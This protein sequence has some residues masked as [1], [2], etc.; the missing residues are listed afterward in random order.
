MASRRM[1]NIN[2]INSARFLKL[3]IDTQNLYFHLCMRADDD[4]VVEAYAVVR[5]IGSSEDNLKLLHAKELVKVLNEDL[6]AYITDWNSHNNIRADRKIDSMYKNLLIQILPEIKVIEP[7]PRTDVKDNSKRL[8]GQS[9][10]SPLVDGGRHRL[11]KVSKDLNTANLSSKDTLS[12]INYEP[13]THPKVLD[14]VANVIEGEERRIDGEELEKILKVA[15]VEN[16]PEK[17][18]LFIRGVITRLWE[19]RTIPLSLKVGLTHEGIRDC[20]RLCRF[21]QIAEAMRDMIMCKKNKKIYFAK[22]LISAI[23]ESVIIETFME[24]GEN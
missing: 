8:G 9:T 3:P 17:T 15:G 22:A 16:Y 23:T 10:D 18:A 13:P 5:L 6:V 4:G 12:F 2:I 19:D 21:E 24:E 1:F 11:G 14:K 20:L 7:K